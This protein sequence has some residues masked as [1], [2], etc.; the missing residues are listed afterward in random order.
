MAGRNQPN[1]GP[2]RLVASESLE[3]LILEHAEDLGLHGQ[4]HVADLIE[5]ERPARALLKLADAAAVGAG[6]GA[7]LV[8]KQLALQQGLGDGRTVQR[9]ERSPRRRPC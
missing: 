1:V 6:E 4:W 8:S 5:K 2:D 3:G 9:Q 7:T